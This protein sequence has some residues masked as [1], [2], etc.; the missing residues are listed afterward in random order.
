MSLRTSRRA[1]VLAS[2]LL[3]LGT[4]LTLMAPTAQADAAHP[5]VSCIGHHTVN[6]TEG[7]KDTT[8]LHHGTATS[9][10]GLSDTEGTVAGNT[11]CKPGMNGGTNVPDAIL[12]PAATVTVTFTETAS[13]T[14]TS[15]TGTSWSGKID[16]KNALGAIVATSQ[17]ANGTLPINDKEHGNGI[18]KAT[19]DVISG[20]GVNGKYVLHGDSN[21]T[22]PNAC[23][24]GTVGV[25]KETG[26]DSFSIY[27]N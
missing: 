7:L 26:S 16:W 10:Y 15:A 5:L 9:D 23:S 6:F 22:A 25:K 14:E 27:K 2:A 18:V 20:P 19:A 12:Y 3:P 4:A 21:T 13:C 8:E 11:G 1:A 17:L 24:S